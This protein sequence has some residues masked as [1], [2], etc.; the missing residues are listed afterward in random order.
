MIVAFGD[1]LS[2]GLG[3]ETGGS[4]PTS[5]NKNSIRM[6]YKYH[7]VNLGV[8]G[9]TTTGGFGRLDYALSL[10]PAVVILELG[11]NDG[12]RGVPVAAT[13]A[14]LERDDRGV[15]KSRRLGVACGN[16]AAAELRT[17]LHPRS[18]K[19]RTKIWQRST[20]L[21]LI[22]FL[23][24]DIAGAIASATGLM[25][26]DGIHPT[27]K[28]HAIIADTVFRYLAAADRRESLITGRRIS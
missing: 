18:S 22:P 16:D 2:E 8:S 26:R 9:D 28:G 20:R 23:M 15:P 13:K 1:S 4:F 19:R 17:R 24:Q 6:D 5:C 25:Q 21:R 14:N 27:A 11:G 7:V 12:L 3:V 10:K